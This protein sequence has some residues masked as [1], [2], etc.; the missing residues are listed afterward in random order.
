MM[1]VVEV[2]RA[3]KLLEEGQGCFRDGVQALR[4]AIIE[5]NQSDF[6]FE[7]LAG[8]EGTEHMQ[9]PVTEDL[10]GKLEDVLNDLTP[11]GETVES[12]SLEVSDG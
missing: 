10:V 11:Y 12:L 2:Q 6:R 7:A 5:L 1:R 3:R 8:L 9:F 4:D